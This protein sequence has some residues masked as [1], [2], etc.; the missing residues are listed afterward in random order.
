MERNYDGLVGWFDDKSGGLD[1]GD[2]MLGL[3]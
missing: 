1:A 3:S 2:L